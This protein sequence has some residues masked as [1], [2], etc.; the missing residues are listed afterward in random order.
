MARAHHFQCYFLW[1]FQVH[2][3]IEG[4]HLSIQ[5][6]Y[7]KCTLE[8]LH[9]CSLAISEWHTCTWHELYYVHAIF[10]R[11]PCYFS[12]NQYIIN[13]A[14]IE[15]F[16]CLCVCAYTWERECVCVLPWV[17]NRRVIIYI[18]VIYYNEGG[19]LCWERERMWWERK[20]TR[21]YCFRHR[22]SQLV[23]SV[24]GDKIFRVHYTVYITRYSEVLV[25][26]VT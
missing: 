17:Y 19:Q 6:N 11:F 18:R 4:N 8:M 23:S 2:F 22:H 21:F 16:L 12:V 15:F 24:L 26:P 1:T 14:S 10:Y 5:L 20:R 3:W 25:M 7:L 9:W 13:T